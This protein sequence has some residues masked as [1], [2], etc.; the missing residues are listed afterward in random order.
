MIPPITTGTRVRR[1]L[2]SPTPILPSQTR[3]RAIQLCTESLAPFVDASSAA[4]ILEK[5]CPV[6]PPILVIGALITRLLLPRFMRFAPQLPNLLT[7]Y[8]SFALLPSH[9]LL[10]STPS[11]LLPRNNMLSS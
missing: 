6:S 10:H 7:S 8:S 2:Y 4:P 3:P 11:F 9:L 5:L 1:V